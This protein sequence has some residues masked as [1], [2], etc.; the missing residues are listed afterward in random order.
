MSYFIYEN[1][2]GFYFHNEE[3]CIYLSILQVNS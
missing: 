1:N 3:G 2:L